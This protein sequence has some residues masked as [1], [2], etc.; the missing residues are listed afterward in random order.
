[1][2]KTISILLII[3]SITTLSAQNRNGGNRRMGMNYGEDRTPK[4]ETEKNQSERLQKTID[5][6]KTDLNLDELQLIVV[7]NVMTD[8]QKTQ[9][10]ILKKTDSQ[11]N[12]LT[13]LQASND[14]T[15]RQIMDILNNDQKEKYKLMI[16]D[17]KNRFENA[18][19]R[20]SGN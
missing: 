18:T 20:R 9:K 12:K 17:R 13:E 2:K 5:K 7:T 14:S 4:G 10:N 1:M 3:L 11:E 15:D 19:G 6:L 8:S 16:E